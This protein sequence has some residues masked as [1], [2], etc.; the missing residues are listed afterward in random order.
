MPYHE[1][2]IRIPDLFKDMLIK[3]LTQKGCLGAIEDNGSLIAYFPAT[4]DIDIITTELVVQKALLEGTNN[5]HQL[6]FDYNLIPDQDWNE[7]WKKGFRP[8]DVG[9]QFTILPPWEDERSGRINLI[10]DPGMAFGTGHHETTR[11]CLVLMERYVGKIVKGRFLDLGTGTGLLAIAA[12]KFGFQEVVAV[13]TDP[14]ALEA[15]YKNCALNNVSN[16][17]IRSGSIMDNDGNF[18]FIVANII[19]GV[20]MLLAPDI[21]AHIKPSSVAVLSGILAEQVDEV[22]KAY[23]QVGMKLI[24]VFPDGKWVSLVLRKCGG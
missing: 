17:T 20:L 1:F 8:L 16:V 3:R 2:T 22:I 5:R 11:S 14:L 7:S 12:S 21:S 6:T 10:I 23:G 15:A 4:N 19:S 18:D 9:Q 13:D 24:E